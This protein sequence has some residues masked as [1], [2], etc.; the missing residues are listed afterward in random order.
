M[1]AYKR[2]DLK[3]QLRLFLSLYKM[4][5]SLRVGYTGLE[6]LKGNISS[7]LT[8]FAAICISLVTGLFFMACNLFLVK[9]FQIPE[10]SYSFNF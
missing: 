7:K 10:S 3:L 5:I 1:S 4:A 8:R 2:P 9:I 6:T